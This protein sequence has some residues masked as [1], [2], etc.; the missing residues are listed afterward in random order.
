MR[1]GLQHGYSLFELL[2]TLA[3]AVVILTVGLPSFGRLA[4]DSRL[5]AEI[6]P[7][8]HGIHL[9]RKESILRREFATLCPSRDG[10]TCSP[11]AD[12]SAGW[13]LFVNADRDDP[14][15]RDANEP[16]LKAHAGDLRVRIDANRRSFTLR[17]IGR[18]ATN[19]TLTFCD[20]AGRIPARALVV[21][22]TGRPRVALADTRGRSYRCDD[23]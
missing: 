2:M 14:P 3:L 6:D 20:R 22:Y 4:A 8:F 17:A 7:L 1:D 23:R 16:I 18:R 5:R 11:D 19:G 10:R 12:W 15:R 13:I 9:A 21:S